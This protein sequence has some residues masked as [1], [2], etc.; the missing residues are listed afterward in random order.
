MVA[1]HQGDQFTY[2]IWTVDK[3]DNWEDGRELTRYIV[4]PRLSNHGLPDISL[5]TIQDYEQLQFE[6]L[7]S[8][9]K[10]KTTKMTGKRN[11]KRAADKASR[12]GPTHRKQHKEAPWIPKL[13][14][15]LTLRTADLTKN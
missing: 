3:D 1:D 13:D 15:K 8:L 7:S 10:W 2:K 6:T 14:D 9:L 4:I 11:H 5:L 12:P